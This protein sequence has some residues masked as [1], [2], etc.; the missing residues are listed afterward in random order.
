MQQKKLTQSPGLLVFVIAALALWALA[1][2]AAFVEGH[3]L[4]RPRILWYPFFPDTPFTD[5]TIFRAQFQAFRTPRFW[6]AQPFPF[7]YPAP[8]ALA[9][10][11][12]FALPGT[13]ALYFLTFLLASALAGAIAAVIILRQH[14]LSSGSALFL[15]GMTLA[16]SYPFMF[17]FDRG[18]IEVINWVFVSLAIAAFWCE[19]WNLSAALLG[20]AISLKLFPVVLL[21][22]FLA[23]KKFTATL[24][25]IGAA[26]ALDIAALAIL[27]PTLGI[28]HQ[29]IA[30]G[31]RYFQDVYV[32][33]LRFTEIPF[34]HSLFAVV[35]QFASKFHVADSAH[36][37]VLARWY[38]VIAAAGA[39]LIYFTRIVR[40]PRVNQILILLTLSVLLPPVSGDYTLV[41]L[42]AGWLILAIFALQAPPGIV[43]SR[44]LPIC[45]FLLA[46]AF[47]P[48]TY[49]VIGRFHIAGLLKA[50]ALSVL[51]ILLLVCP[52]EEAYEKPLRTA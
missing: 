2:L 10:A 30:F 38:S 11:A 39:L 37:A 16:T 34:D 29:H 8:A 17:L 28:A 49:V 14:G 35:K 3:I 12:F 51:V 13:R 7:T 50:L 44:V 40:L 21:G 31:L 18:N 42:Y 47:S 25:A 1:G 36:L 5:F 23:R 4:R 33:H 27:G 15:S 24:I 20:V 32:N 41:H 9:F 52:L 22:L 46:V 26:V 19:Q 43:R 6:H 48:E 45:F